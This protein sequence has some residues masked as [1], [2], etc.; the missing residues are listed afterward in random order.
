MAKKR[1]S[2]DDLVNGPGLAMVAA[3]YSG[4]EDEM[5]Q[6]RYKSAAQMYMQ[7]V[8]SDDKQSDEHVQAN[9]KV[10]QVIG[11][12]VSLYL[13]GIK[14]YS[15]G[16]VFSGLIRKTLGSKAL[17]GL[18][19][20]EAIKG[21]SLEAYI[22]ASEEVAKA[23][24]VTKKYKDDVSAEGKKKMNEAREIIEKNEPYAKVYGFIHGYMLEALEKTY[25]P[26]MM[27]GVYRRL[28][29]GLKEAITELPGKRAKAA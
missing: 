25:L 27:D 20:L 5:S 7:Y 15:V 2:L 23:K 21:H 19:N 24:K 6:L 9:H 18:D 22:T 3:K 26:A 13:E 4:S 11:S 14:Q 12:G 10:D 8:F 1:Q 16:E 17:K 28:G 29:S